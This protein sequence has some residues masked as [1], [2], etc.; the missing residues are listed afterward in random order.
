VLGAATGIVAAF[1]CAIVAMLA[2]DAGLVDARSPA[3]QRAIQA[4]EGEAVAH[5]ELVERSPE[6][7]H[8]L[9]QWADT[10]WLAEP[11]QVRTFLTAAAA[12][13]GFVGFVLGAWLAESAAALLT[14][15]VGAIFLLVGAMP[16]LARYSDRVA[17]GPHP[18][19]WLLLWLAVSLAGWLFQ[20]SR[21]AGRRLPDEPRQAPHQERRRATRG[22]PSERT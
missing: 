16:L 1:A 2:I 7:V 20:S 9:V 11:K 5:R 3:D 15:L 4:A 22:D 19:G 12:G 21:A 8:G 13:G 14:S 10:R 18:I 17:Q 6:F